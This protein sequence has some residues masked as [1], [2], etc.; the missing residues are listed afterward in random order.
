MSPADPQWARIEPLLPI[1]C[2]GGVGCGAIKRVIDAIAWKYRTGSPGTDLPAEYGSWKGAQP[3]ADVGDGRH[4]GNG[5]SPLGSPRPT[6]K[7]NRTG[8]SGSTRPAC[9]VIRRKGP[10]SAIDHAAPVP[11]PA[12]HDHGPRGGDRADSGAEQRGACV[13]LGG[14][15]SP[16]V[17]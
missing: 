17:R 1:G 15:G 13:R 3:A 16:V 9:A 14:R 2:R 4:L 10:G 7:A 8:S 5:S 12:V 11:A 6:P